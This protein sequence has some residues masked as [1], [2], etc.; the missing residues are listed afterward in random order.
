MKRLLPLLLLAACGGGGDEGAPSN[1]GLSLEA[2]RWAFAYSDVMPAHPDPGV[3]SFSFA[4]P[5]QDGVHYLL[6]GYNGS[7]IGKESV[8]IAVVIE[9]SPATVWEYGYGPNNQCL[10]PASVR[11]MI[12]KSGDDLVDPFGRWWATAGIR[13]QNGAFALTVPLTPES[14]SDVYG[15]RGDD[16]L[17]QFRIAKE[18]VVYFGFYLLCR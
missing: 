17:E 8:T 9:A 16:A 13:L 12:Q 3:N 6:T 1:P 5:Q 15:L 4:F 11:V 10:T 14:W 2:N 18:N 7:L